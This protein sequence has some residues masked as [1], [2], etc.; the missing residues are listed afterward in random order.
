M[1]LSAIGGVDYLSSKQPQACSI[2]SLFQEKA[3]SKINE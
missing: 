1:N 3:R 2:M